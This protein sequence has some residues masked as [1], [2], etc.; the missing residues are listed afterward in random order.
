MTF[1]R[2]GH[3][4][5][6][7][8]SA[9]RSSPRSPKTC[10][11]IECAGWVDLK[12]PLPA[13]SELALMYGDISVLENHHLAVGFTLLQADNCDIFWNLNAK[14]W[15]SLR[16]MVIDMVRQGAAPWHELGFIL[17]VLT[18]A[19]ASPGPGHRH[20]QAHEPAG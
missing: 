13:E 7:L 16:R 19:S 1:A 15:L 14:Q 10:L 11:W 5:L 17:C 12:L 8:P 9:G 18:P 20:V 2:S 4:E 6:G 3:L